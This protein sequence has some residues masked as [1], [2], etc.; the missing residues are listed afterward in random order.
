[1]EI[2]VKFGE[3]PVNNW[4]WRSLQDGERVSPVLRAFSVILRGGRV[5]TAWCFASFDS[6]FLVNQVWDKIRSFWFI[7]EI[8]WIGAEKVRFL[9]FFILSFWIWYRKTCDQ[10]WFC[11][12]RR[13][14]SQSRI[15]CWM[16][17]RL[18]GSLIR[19]MR[20]V[21]IR[22]SGLVKERYKN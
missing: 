13:R 12:E 21:E 3:K 1:M 17:F 18:L 4:Y 22:L 16:D 11:T 2:L 15:R 10:D 14:R 6:S 9:I 7:V 8:V 5:S 20:F 19:A